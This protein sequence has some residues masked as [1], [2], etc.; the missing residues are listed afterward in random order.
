MNFI[1]L[2]L[3]LR[4]V[5]NANFVTIVDVTLRH[6]VVFTTAGINLLAL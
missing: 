6:A 1:V 3:D 5:E 4:I 2:R